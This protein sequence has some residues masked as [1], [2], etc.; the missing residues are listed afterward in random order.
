VKGTAG[1][2]GDSQSEGVEFAEQLAR[3]RRRPSIGVDA[4]DRIV[5]DAR[6]LTR[7]ST[8][9]GAR[10]EQM[11]LK[12]NV[13]VAL[14]LATIRCGARSNPHASEAPASVSSRLPRAVRRP[15]LPRLASDSRR[16]RSFSAAWPGERCHNGYD[17]SGSDRPTPPKRLHALRR[18][19]SSRKFPAS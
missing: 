4:A 19:G 18:I 1:R 2:A 8:E 13:L 11:S 16:Y 7:M 10:V 12:H 6:E 9:R 5:R 17:P 14:S 3:H 15:R